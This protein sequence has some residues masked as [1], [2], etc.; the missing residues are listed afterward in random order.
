MS[1]K[2]EYKYSTLASLNEKNTDPVHFYGTIV[3]AS[4]PYKTDKRSVVTCRVVDAS[5]AKKGGAVQEKDFVTVVF[6]AKN[7]ED[8]P[9]IQRI[10]DVIRVHRA[11]FLFHNDRKQLNVNLFYRGSWCLFVGNEKDAPL[12]PKVVNENKEA[13]FFTHTPYNFSGKSFTWGDEDVSILK[14][15]RK[16]TKEQFSKHTVVDTTTNVTEQ[17]NCIKKNKDF[18]LIGKVV[19]CKS[20][21][22]WTNAVTI[23]DSNGTSWTG[24]LFKK[25]FPHLAVGE[26][27]RVRSVNA[28]AA[29]ELSL[30][31][32]S[33]VLNFI[34]SAKVNT[35]LAKISAATTAAASAVTTITNKKQA[36]SAVT[37]LKNLFFAPKTCKGSNFHAQ[38]SVLKTDPSGV[39]DWTKGK[40]KKASTSVKLVVTD[41]SNPSDEKAYMI[42]LEDDKFFG[43]H[44]PAA[45][46]KI[47]TGKKN[48]VDAILER[49]GK[50]YFITN[51]KLR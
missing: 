13:N 43:K 4:F 18:D 17:E 48:F 38:F 3:D 11:D 33:N 10:G 30:A 6:Y 49:K 7:F 2:D 40:G 42:H 19:K 16:W 46:K 37:S 5:L 25:K 26:V 31:N 1:K 14:N 35:Q 21:D 51:T 34:S 8:L 44:A 9:I 20:A 22:Q 23:N 27:V 39:A 32:H 15:L 28:N 24:N 36:G 29:H 41:H 45:A 50:N 47:L 12:E